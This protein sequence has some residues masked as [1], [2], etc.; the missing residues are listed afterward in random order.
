L[1]VCDSGPGVPEDEQ[2]SI[3]ERFVR[4]KGATGTGSGLGLA[5]VRDIAAIHGAQ[6]RAFS[7]AP[8]GLCVELRMVQL[9]RSAEV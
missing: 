5:I 2:Q 8:C 3:F 4:G 1:R 7:A 6:V 9:P